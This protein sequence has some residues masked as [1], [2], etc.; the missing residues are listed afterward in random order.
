VALGGGTGLPV[1]LRALKGIIARCG[2]S[3][4][5][6]VTVTDDGGSSGRL[7]RDYNALP[8]GDIRNC[9]VA[10]SENEPLM[11][12][13]FQYRYRG[14][15]GLGGHSVGNLILTALADCCRSYLKA[16]ETSGEVLAIRG[17]ILPSTLENVVLRARLA[18]GRTIRGETRISRNPTP[19]LR[20]MTEPPHPPPAP[21]VLAALRQADLIL[22]G[23]GSLFTSI[24]P[25]LLVRGVARAIARSKAPRVLIGNLM[26][27]PRETLGFTAADHLAALT[28]TAGPG[29]V[30]YYLA[31]SRP[32]SRPLRRLYER[33]GAG[34]VRL[35]PPSLRSLGVVPVERDLLREDRGDRKIRHHGGKLARALLR[36]VERHAAQGA[37]ATR[38]AAAVRGAGASRCA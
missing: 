14:D 10:L 17:R 34:P 21:G 11:S 4:T 15:N 30:D 31:N 16:I 33:D 19:I 28:R 38:E 23:P 5:G 6:I 26:T 18:G 9:L 29:L 32:I 3:L 7:R 8:V 25:N 22:L 2:G 27:Q 36:I 35:H 13:L 24:I 20:V 37:G 1:V 12:R